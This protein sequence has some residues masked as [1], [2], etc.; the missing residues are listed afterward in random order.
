VI[1]E[2]INKSK[3][4]LDHR[5]ADYG[6]GLGLRLVEKIITKMSWQY[7]NEEIVGGRHVTISFNESN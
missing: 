1:I 5:G 6:Y 2:N 3:D 4:E 7:L